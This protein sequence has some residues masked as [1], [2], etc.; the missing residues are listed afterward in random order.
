MPLALFRGF[1]CVSDVYDSICTYVARD[2]DVYD[3]R[4]HVCH[5]RYVRVAGARC[6]L[7]CL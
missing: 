1:H 2:C 3:C 7:R 4:T 6:A 5:T